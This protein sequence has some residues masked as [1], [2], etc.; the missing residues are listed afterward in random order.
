MGD[1]QSEG[2]GWIKLAGPLNHYVLQFDIVYILMH[3]EV[4]GKVWRS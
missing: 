4:R 3:E 1:Y 2:M